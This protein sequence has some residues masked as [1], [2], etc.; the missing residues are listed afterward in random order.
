MDDP[1]CGWY[2]R[3]QSEDRTLALIPAVH[4]AHGNRFGSLQIISDTGI[5]TIA[6][7]GEK[8]CVDK[9]R[10]YA[11]LG[12]SVFSETGIR[13]NERRDDISLL[14]EL[15]FG[16]LSRIRYDMMG[17]FCCVP[18]ME[19][20][21]SIASMRHTVNGTLWINGAEYRFRD[22][23]GYLEGDRGR[24]FPRRYA[25]T[26]CFFEGGSLMLSVADIPLG[27]LCFTGVIGI[28]RVCKK[29]YRLA[30]YLGARAAMIRGGEVLIRQGSMTLYAA[31]QENKAYALKA[32]T[33][34][35]MTRSIRENVSCRARYRFCIGQKTVLSLETT[36]AAFEYEYP[37]LGG[38]S[39]EP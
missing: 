22:G 17:P 19:C 10:P 16:D 39:A 33:E 35:D 36:Q 3:C 20:R 8:A 34:G 31:L 6:F 32:P 29:E 38:S 13:L 27:R 9:H 14:G 15:C 26:Q 37:S 7:P 11:V 30:T 25:W 12:N 28:I 4:A 5:R 2:F 21:H 24:S 1:F 23:I 18:F